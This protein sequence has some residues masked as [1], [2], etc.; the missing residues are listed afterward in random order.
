MIIHASVAIY[1]ISSILALLFAYLFSEIVCSGQ[2]VQS[3]S[4][5]RIHGAYSGVC[6]KRSKRHA[7]VL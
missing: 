6:R 3:G 1:M 7:Q 4:S 5:V 2:G